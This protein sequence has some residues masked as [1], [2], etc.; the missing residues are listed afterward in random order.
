VGTSGTVG[1]AGTPAS[2]LLAGRL[3]TGLAQVD[4]AAAARW[5]A[6]APGAFTLLVRDRPGGHEAGYGVNVSEVGLDLVADTADPDWSVVGSP[7]A[8]DA[9]LSGEVNLATALR[10][11]DLRYCDQGEND[12]IVADARIS[13]MAVLLGLPSPLADRDVMPVPS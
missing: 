7:R 10:R 8:W 5:A 9:V 3:A 11:C 2:R 1:T 12:M 13:M 4:G 6:R